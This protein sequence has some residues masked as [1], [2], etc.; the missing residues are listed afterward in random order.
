[1]YKIAFVVLATSALIIG[2]ASAAPKAKSHAAVKA[3]RLDSARSAYASTTTP[4][5][6]ES[7]SIFYRGPTYIGRY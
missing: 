7:R 6:W 5:G 1:M 3:H 4:D 2:A